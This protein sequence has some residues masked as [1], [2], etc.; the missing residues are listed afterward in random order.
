[1]NPPG[2]SNPYKKNNYQNELV[3]Y[4]KDWELIEQFKYLILEAE[5]IIKNPDIFMRFPIN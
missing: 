3:I 2:S 5:E 1:M 4:P